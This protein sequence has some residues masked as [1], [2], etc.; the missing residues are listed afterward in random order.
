M[1]VM[2]LLI[3]NN[4]IFNEDN[5]NQYNWSQQDRQ[6]LAQARSHFVQIHLNNIIQ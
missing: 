3:D 1:S 5:W 4:T 2:Q 6:T